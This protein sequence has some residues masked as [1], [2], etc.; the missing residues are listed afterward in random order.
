M[1]LLARSLFHRAR[2]TLGALPAD[3]RDRALAAIDAFLDRPGPAPFVAA[4]RS[5]PP[6]SGRPT[7][8][9][10]RAVRADAAVRALRAKLYGKRSA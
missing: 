3:G 5:S 2:D 1:E 9:A 4:V 7:A 8:H 6:R 10:E